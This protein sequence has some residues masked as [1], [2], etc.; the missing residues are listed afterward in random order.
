M[1]RTDGRRR[2]LRA[3]PSD[4]P[5]DRPGTGRRLDR[6]RL[7]RQLHRRP[8]PAHPRRPGHPRAR[9][10]TPP[11]SRSSSTRSP[12]GP[13]CW[14]LSW[15]T[16]TTRSPARAMPEDGSRSAAPR[17]SPITWPA[18]RPSGGPGG[19]PTT[20]T[21]SRWPRWSAP[22]STAA[23]SSGPSPIGRGARPLVRLPGPGRGPALPLL[24][25]DRG[26][27]R[28]AG[29][30]ARRPPQGRPARVRPR[31]GARIPRLGLR[32]APG[33]QRPVQPR[34]P[35][36]DRLAIR[37]GHVRP[38]VRRPQRQRRRPTA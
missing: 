23:W 28:P 30:G 10:P 20:A 4:R 35:G 11:T 5:D 2:P 38:A 13:R 1:E 15:C 31:R 26:R 6:R 9:A 34:T 36:G 37:R 16:L 19:S 7:R 21:S 18:R 32:P 17:P 14:P 22:S 8:R 25:T 27:P 24:A 12:S 33:R 29:A 3:G